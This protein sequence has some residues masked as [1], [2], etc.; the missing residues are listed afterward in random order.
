MPSFNI[1]RFGEFELSVRARTLSREGVGIALPSKTFEVL[2]YLVSNSGRV[3]TKDELLKGVWPDSF[4][5][6]SNLTQHV[7]RL[8]KALQPAPY[9]APYIVTIPGRGYQFSAVVE[10]VVA[11]SASLAPIPSTSIDAPGEIVVKTVRER[12][13]YRAEEIV[14]RPTTQVMA[15]PRPGWRTVSSVSTIAL[16]ALGIWGWSASH[17]PNRLPVG[18]AARRSIGVLG[19]R[20]LSGRPEEGWLSTALAEMLTTEL[21]A[22]EKLR[23]VSGE[24]IART[25]IDLHLADADSLS[26][27]TL[28]RLH[29]DLNSV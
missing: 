19:F 27:S 8:R 13:T 23:L 25:K 15:P 26:R 17:H 11:E 29:K 4:V 22:G 10:S 9:S 2:L 12:S 20:N 14:Q 21:V 24:D 3:V 16:A 18:M 1:Y 7:F 28:A 6:E 5:E